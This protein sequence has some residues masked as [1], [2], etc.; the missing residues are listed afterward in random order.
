[1][2]IFAG[3]SKGTGVGTGV[4]SRAGGP[5]RRGFTLIDAV[6]GLAALAAVAA[7]AMPMG[8]QSRVQ[9]R[10]Q[11]SASNLMQIGQ[12]SAM[13]ALDH[14]GLIHTYTW[15]GPRGS[16]P[17]YK[18]PDGNSYTAF[19][20]T[21]AAALQL[22]SI[23]MRRTGRIDGD[24]AIMNSS[25]R[26]PHRRMMNLI[27]MDYLDRPFPDPLFAD[28]SDAKMLQWQA[29]PL[30]ITSANNIPYAPGGDFSGYDSEGGWTGEGVR[31][32]WAYSSS[33][34]TTVFAWQ[35]DQ[36]N[37]PPSFSPGIYYPTQTTPHLYPSSF[38]NVFIAEGRNYAEVA[39][40]SG[41]VHYF[42]EFDR[43]QAGSP[44]FAYDHARPAKLMFD[45]SVN[46]WASGFASESADPLDPRPRWRQRYVPLHE[47]P[48]PLTGFG[49]ETL[50]SMRYRWT[51][52][53]LRGLDYPLP[54][55][56]GFEPAR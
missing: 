2:K 19:N 7:V 50:L 5:A 40:P 25:V 16:F 28:P 6:A 51:F 55:P 46:E 22:R 33:Y 17:S 34:Q 35:P 29:N 43:R 48:L 9:M 41:K 27:L 31:Q 1:M 37:T 13:Y 15:T 47:F 12:A 18:L 39:F 38:P 53:G 42:E 20:D 11:S 8:L 4:G 3:D 23:L 26:L 44:Y 10:G 30:D 54:A 14:E 49:E 21:Q 56:K 36:P 24:H 45:G 32:R 52:G